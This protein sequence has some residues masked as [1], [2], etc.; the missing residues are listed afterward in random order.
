VHIP[1]PTAVELIR[2]GDG[3]LALALSTDCLELLVPVLVRVCDQQRHLGRPV[4][5]VLDELVTAGRRV[6]SLASLAS[7]GQRASVSVVE[8]RASLLTV[9][10]AVS[11][12]SGISAR[13]LRRKARAGGVP[14]AVLD[15]GLWLIPPAALLDLQGGH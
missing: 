1:A 13:T 15:H 10:E 6:V 8:G 7:A 4:P 12:L 3:E 14:G 11:H 9:R 2:R 5:A